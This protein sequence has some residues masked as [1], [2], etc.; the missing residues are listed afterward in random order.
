MSEAEAVETTAQGL[1]WMHGV[2]LAGLVLMG[3]WVLRTGWG[4]RALA[5]ARRRRNV[6]PPPALMAVMLGWL[7]GTSGAAAAADWLFAGAAPW[8]LALYRNV[9]YLVVAGSISASAIILAWC[10]FGR[11]LR[12]FGLN[13]RMVHRDAAAAAVYL[14]AIW[15]LLSVSVIL[16]PGLGRLIEGPDFKM[17]RHE[18]LELLETHPVAALRVSIFL[19]GAV[20]AP[21]LEELLFRGLFQTMLRDR[22]RNAWAAICLTAGVFAVV[23]PDVAHWPTLFILAVCLGYAY[24]KSGSLL[25]PIFIHALFNGISVVSVL[26]GG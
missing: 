21:V 24:E 14:L 23:H 8:R 20:A 4:R 18:Q 25:R 5:N 12:G 1:H 17:P 15:P 16:T 9:A 19:V 26:L 13:Y 6:L 2:Y 7:V 10:Y 22:L 11:R 3:V